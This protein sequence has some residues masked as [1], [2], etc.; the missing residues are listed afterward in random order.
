MMITPEYGYPRQHFPAPEGGNVAPLNPEVAAMR[1]TL[2]KHGAEAIDPAFA[3]AGPDQAELI[4]ANKRL[5]ITPRDDEYAT[6]AAVMQRAE[7]PYPTDTTGSPTVVI[8]EIPRDARTLPQVMRSKQPSGGRIIRDVFET[9]GQSLDRIMQAAQV[10]PAAGQVALRKMLILR[11]ENEV[12]LMPPLAFVPVESGTKPAL[13]DEMA[14]Q[15]LPEYSRFGGEAL[16][17][18][19]KRGLK[20]GNNH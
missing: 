1:D 20:H 19:F 2:L 8:A 12:M 17:D 4:F 7:L 18:A 10:S 13:V 15:L 9:V 5:L 6:Y 16:L 11:S 14:A 3:T